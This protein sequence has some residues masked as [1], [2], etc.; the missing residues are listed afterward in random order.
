M[1]YAVISIDEFETAAGVT[2]AAGIHAFWSGKLEDAEKRRWLFRSYCND[3][4]AEQIGALPDFF[5]DEYEAMFAGIG[6]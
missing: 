6:V 3:C 4:F 5:L 2:S 1:P